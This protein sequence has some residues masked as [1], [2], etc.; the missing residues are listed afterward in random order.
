[1]AAAVTSALA[2]PAWDGLEVRPQEGPGCR[3]PLAGGE[4]FVLAFTHSVDRLPVEDHYRV[5][6]GRI[7]QEATR[8]RQFGA[9]MGH[10]HGVG[11][12]RADGD[13]WE[14][15]GMGREVGDLVV[16]AGGPQV[17]HLLHHPGG[18]VALSGRWAGQRVTIRPERQSTIQRALSSLG[19]PCGAD[20]QTVPEEAP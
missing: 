13:W 19:G 6:D 12:G 1:M 5:E 11:E 3:L 18:T 9:G 8:L 14:V 2:W 17:G 15:T 20:S 4:T 10:I 7:V 16:R